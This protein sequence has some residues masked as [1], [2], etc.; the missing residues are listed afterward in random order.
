MERTID[1][2]VYIFLSSRPRM[3]SFLH[4]RTRQYC[5]GPSLAR[6]PTCQG[7]LI[8][9]TACQTTCFPRGA[10]PW[11]RDEDFA[12]AYACVYAKLPVGDGHKDRHGVLRHG[13]APTRHVAAK[14]SASYKLGMLVETFPSSS[15]TFRL[16]ML[17]SKNGIAR[18][19][20]NRTS[21]ADYPSVRYLLYIYTH[22][23]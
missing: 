3:L 12:V 14:W 8:L 20:L 21:P 9:Y 5:V 10:W 19:S 16:F 1:Y 2:G 6:H 11:N 18:D 22:K 23:H 7:R 15:A 13:H 17:M 4:A